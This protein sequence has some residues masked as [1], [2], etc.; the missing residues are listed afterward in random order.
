MSLKNKGFK[1][2]SSSS[3]L[4]IVSTILGDI[5][6]DGEVNV[7]DIVALYSY[8]LGNTEGV[9]E[10]IVD[11]NGD[12][13]GSVDVCAVGLQSLRTGQLYTLADVQLGGLG[14]ADVTTAGSTNAVVDLYI[15][16]NIYN[17]V[18]INVDVTALN[19]CTAVDFTAGD[20]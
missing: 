7:T 16:G 12:G 11:V 20:L 6:N 15:A 1:V 2:V 19:C 18:F 3:D 4:V 13:A 5:N 8:I 10:S 14:H 9:A 17:L